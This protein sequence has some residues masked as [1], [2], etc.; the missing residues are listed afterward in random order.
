[1]SAVLDQAIADQLPSVSATE[2]VAGIQKVGRTVAAHGAVLITKHD[3]PAFVLMSV[4]R[5]R[6]LQRAAEPDL[7]TLNAEFDALLAGMQGRGDAMA[8]AFA[9][10]PEAIGTA[11][12][13]A[14]KPRRKAA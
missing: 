9:M 1:M 4:E 14:A 13:K 8:A 2:L 7:G 11:A 3:Q 5:Y 6:E 12:V 10:A